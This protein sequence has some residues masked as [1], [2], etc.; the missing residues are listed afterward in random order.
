MVIFGPQVQEIGDMAFEGSQYLRGVAFD[1]G[2]KRIGSYAFARCK[3]IEALALMV[4]EIGVGSFSECERVS[5][6]DIGPKIT[7]IPDNAF[8]RTGSKAIG[9]LKLLN[10][11]SGN[12]KR[13]G[14][15][16]FEETPLREVIIPETMESVSERAFYECRQLEK[17]TISART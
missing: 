7:S 9:E 3:N 2:L 11:F 8:Y 15:S 17:I 14:K 5:L 10:G 13:I 16:A 6:I 4:E 12:L 1:V